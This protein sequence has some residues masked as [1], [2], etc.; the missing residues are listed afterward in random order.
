M[1]KTEKNRNFS[2]TIYVHFIYIYVKQKNYIK[3]EPERKK[4]NVIFKVSSNVDWI[5]MNGMENDRHVFV[6]V[7]SLLMLS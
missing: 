3:I 2:F 5:E 7:D 1:Q 4:K 6:Y